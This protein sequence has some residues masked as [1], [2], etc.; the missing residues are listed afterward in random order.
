MTKKGTKD[1]KDNNQ[2]VVSINTA[3]GTI[4]HERPKFLKRWDGESNEL[5]IFE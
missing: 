5:E 4:N 1:N 2:D 3:R